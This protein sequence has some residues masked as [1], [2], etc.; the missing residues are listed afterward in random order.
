MGDRRL[1]LTREFVVAAPVQRVWAE[2]AAVE[3]WPSWAHHIRSVRLEPPG[4]LVPSTVGTLRLAGGVTSS[5]RMVEL[6]PGRSWR[7]EGG[8]L[9]LW[10]S[11]DHVL[12][13]LDPARTRVRFDVA[14]EG[15]G[16]G[17]LGRLFAAIYARNL[18]R[19]I[20]R[21]IARLERA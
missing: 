10:V 12:T 5:F 19:A 16:V 8:F 2:L 6:Q 4:E 18:D 9:W 11:Y 17:L 13:P 1:L 3:R 7:W 20:P 14:A 15:P 21:L